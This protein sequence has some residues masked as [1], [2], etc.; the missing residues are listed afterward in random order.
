MSALP[1]SV[2][3]LAASLY[4]LP[5]IADPGCRSLVGRWQNESGSVLEILAVS[6]GGKMEGAYH[7]SSGVDGKAFSLLGW[8][9]NS[10][11]RE[12]A[13]SVAWTVRWGD[14]GSITSWTGTCEVDDSGPHIKAMWHLVRPGEEHSWE[15]VLAN[16]STF[17]PVSLPAK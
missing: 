15:R 11:R 17:R 4:T 16:S 5:A 1:L 12:Q 9:N 2:L 8:L 10:N 7:S 3:I 13:T 6:A 14:Y